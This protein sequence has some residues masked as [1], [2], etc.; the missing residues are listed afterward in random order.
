MLLM[1]YWTTGLKVLMASWWIWEDHVYWMCNAHVGSQLL[2]TTHPTA[3]V[4]NTSHLNDVAPKT[5]L[6]QVAVGYGGQ[7]TALG[8]HAPA[9]ILFG[10]DVV[11]IG[12]NVS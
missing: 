12:I 11:Y 8:S 2:T 9:G 6:S 3:T 4:A 1:V 10:D 7:Q 5:I